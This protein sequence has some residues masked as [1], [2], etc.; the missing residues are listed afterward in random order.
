MLRFLIPSD[1]GGVAV[2]DKRFARS[3]VPDWRGTLP[4]VCKHKR[5]MATLILALSLA[6]TCAAQS[7]G[8]SRESAGAGWIAPDTS[9]F[10]SYDEAQSDPMHSPSTYV[11]TD[12]WPYGVV[13]RAA[14]LGFVDTAFYGV[15]PWTRM[16]FAQIVDQIDDASEALG[17]DEM[18][19]IRD[20]LHKEFS[21]ELKRLR[22]SAGYSA[23]IEQIYSRF[24]GI[25]GTPL[26]DGFHFG[27]TLYN[28]YGRPYYTGSSNITGFAAST[29]GGPIVF[30]VRG[31]Y[32][33]APSQPAY[34]DAVRALIG[35]MDLTPVQPAVAIP[36]RNNFRLIE[37]YTAFN[38]GMI[39]F[40][41]GKQDLWWGPGSGG[42]MLMSN[43]A[44]PFYMGRVTNVTPI[45]IPWLSRV[46]GPMN[47]DFFFGEL[48]GHQY[49]RGPW[50]HGQKLTFRPTNNLELG[51]SR[52]V[53][54][55]GEGHGLTSGSFWRSF[56][57]VGDN[58]STAPGSVNDVGDRR[59]GFDL[60]YRIPGL[61]DWLTYYVDAFTDDDPSPLS[62]PHRA[63][64][65]TGIYIPKFPKLNKLDFR[66]EGL[67]SARSNTA[68][69][70]GRFFYWNAGYRDAYTNK[71]L[72]LGSWVGRQGQGVAIESNYWLS[73]RDRIQVGY[74][75]GMID[76]AFVPGGG[77]LN[78]FRVASTT[79][80]K[81]G[82]EITGGVQYE[83]WYVPVLA[84]GAQSNTTVS[85]KLTFTPCWKLN[86]KSAP[87]HC[88]AIR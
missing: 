40:T 54:F 9:E 86:S 56:V 25:S 34:S 85:V 38:L 4:V 74:R 13:D 51:F 66:A 45:R 80:F 24:A 55:A 32:Q 42:P 50:T 67:L 31:E 16:Q 84:S 43:N 69:F 5:A 17:A 8:H 61:R 88:G 22:G 7:G 82:L 35:T 59:G 62:A 48:A 2:I 58:P 6:A 29:S 76:Q 52:T 64:F 3:D 23:Q 47:F 81:Q 18:Q 57:S 49:P 87:A 28:D 44:E 19:P 60:K 75:R 72:L 71:Q 27:Q 15:R 21:T 26:N 37:A 30:Y 36:T 12:Q 46:M 77:N 78:D 33:H 41:V 11:P 39:Q 1:N 83:R 14:A 10:D 20:V 68:P 63:A 65:N 79:T 53:V 70:R 73:G